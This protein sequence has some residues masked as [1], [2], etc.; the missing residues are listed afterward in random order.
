[1]WNEYIGFKKQSLFLLS[2][3]AYTHIKNIDRWS[4]DVTLVSTA[5]NSAPVYNYIQITE[6]MK[7][8]TWK[9][10]EWNKKSNRNG[11]H[12]VPCFVTLTINSTA[13]YQLNKHF[14]NFSVLNGSAKCH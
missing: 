5:V 1:M 13:F 14:I 12:V 6:K 11:S 9:D 4:T 10:P 2:L 7:Y 8:V 3:P